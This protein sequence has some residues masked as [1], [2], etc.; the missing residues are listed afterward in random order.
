MHKSFIF[1]TPCSRQ[2][3]Y[4]F[5]NIRRYCIAGKF[6]RENVWQIYSFQAFGGKSLVN[7]WISQRFINCNYYFKW[8][9]LVNLQ[10]I[11]QLRQTFY[12]PN[13][14]A[15]W[16]FMLNFCSFHKVGKAAK[17]FCLENFHICWLFISYEE[18]F[19]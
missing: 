14:P 6:G 4:F 10:T 12:L 9:S 13:I 15:I 11:H 7:E 2:T 19:Y 1:A 16:H 5:S 8:F 17:N 3:A 18:T